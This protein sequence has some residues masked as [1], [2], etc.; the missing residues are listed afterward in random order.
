MQY[1]SDCCLLLKAEVCTAHKPGSEGECASLC[2]SGPTYFVIARGSLIPK[3]LCG[4]T[5]PLTGLALQ[6]EVPSL[7]TG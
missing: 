3:P 2:A 5:F 1:K 4:Y 7:R 6:P